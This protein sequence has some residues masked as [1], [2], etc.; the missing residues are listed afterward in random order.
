MNKKTAGVLSSYLLIGVDVL[1]ALF[2]VP[3]L[4]SALGP[5]EYGIYKLMVSTASYLS[6]LDFGLGGTITR[7]IVKYKTEQDLRQQENFMAMGLLLYAGLSVV[8]LMVALGVCLL[9]PKLYAASITADKMHSAQT[10]FMILCTNTA[11]QLFN[12]AYNGLLAAHER[13]SFIKIST[14]V[15]TVLRV[16]LIVLGMHFIRSA[17]LVAIIDL[18]LSVGLLALNILYSRFHVR[19]KI[20]LH[21]WDGKLAKEAL[22]F[23][24]A[25]LVQAI[26]NQFNT[27]VDNIVLGIYSSTAVIAM[28]SLVL[29]LYV[30]YANLST[31]VSSV[32][33]PSISTEVFKGSTD[34]QITEKVIPPSRIQL[35]VLLLTFTGFLLFGKDFILLWVGEGYESVYYLTCVLMLASILD[36]SQ[37]SITSVV[38]AKNMLH[39][40]TWI[41]CISTALNFVVT[42][43][44]VPHFGA[45]GAVAGTAF[46]MIF[47]YGVA[48]NLYY[49]F[50]I[51][52]HM[53]TYYKKTYRGILPAA[54]LAA[55]I[56]IPIALWLPLDGWVGL[57]IKAGCYALIF[58]LLLYRIG[59]NQE[60]RQAVGAFLNKLRR[61]KK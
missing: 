41:L 24:S 35:S 11:V 2:F 59:L 43:L 40:R 7:Y 33:L 38:K 23:T 6:V 58:C 55:M 57:I 22:I 26:I 37:N 3:F 12:H 9:L 60:E 32:Y 4:L 25:I 45:I 61:R 1:V 36:L 47:G 34:A 21:G 48:L 39:G 19:S 44:L 20:K 27:N 8:V 15:K 56:G 51:K 50:F 42:L 28:Y 54:A 5:D 52:I 29:Q 17:L 49:H 18:A 13:F 31:A 10:I 14:I 46:S 53:P 16:L 30:M